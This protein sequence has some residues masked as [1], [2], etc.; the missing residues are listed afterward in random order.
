VSAAFG[1][2]AGPARHRSAA[3]KA[4]AEDV[5]DAVAEHPFRGIFVEANAISPQ[6]MRRIAARR[7]ANGVT[8]VDGC[9]IGPPPRGKATARLYLT[10]EPAAVT[11][12]ARLFD[13]TA[14][15]ARPMDKPLGAA[16][17][18]SEAMSALGVPWG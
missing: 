3:T 1:C 14:V 2:P 9:I 11:A 7:Q 8:P 18:L 6:R 17:A 4:R 13:G 16:S 15:H 5:A 12:T 10:G